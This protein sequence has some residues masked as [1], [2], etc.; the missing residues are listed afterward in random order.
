MQ[1]SSYVGWAKL[2]C[3]RIDS[4]Q[5]YFDHSNIKDQGFANLGNSK[6]LAR[7][8]IPDQARSET[9][10]W[11]KTQARSETRRGGGQKIQNDFSFAGASWGPN[12]EKVDKIYTR[13]EK[14]STKSYFD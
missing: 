5:A 14:F 13:G 4:N 9:S 8:S 2:G 12:L 3:G 1:F 11:G 6:T 10:R 7:E